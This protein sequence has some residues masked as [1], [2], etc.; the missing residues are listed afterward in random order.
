[1][2]EPG[3]W[4]GL[5]LIIE[6]EPGKQLL[7]V[8]W[9]QRGSEEFM[10][11]VRGVCQS[12]GKGH[13]VWGGAWDKGWQGDCGGRGAQGKEHTEQGEYGEGACV[14]SKELF[15]LWP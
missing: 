10:W 12:I 7:W 13:V 6:Y 9:L 3:L 8:L 5:H 4:L 1:M 2:Q 11:W 15:W 14:A